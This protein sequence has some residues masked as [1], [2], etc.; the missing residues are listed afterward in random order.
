[1]ADAVLSLKLNDLSNF[2]LPASASSTTSTTGSES[3]LP[4]IL[5]KVEKNYE[6]GDYLR[7]I[8]IKYDEAVDVCE[9]SLVNQKINFIELGILNSKELPLYYSN[10]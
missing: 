10:L 4:N 9:V 2:S 1:L 7:C 8:V 5:A 6:V 3:S